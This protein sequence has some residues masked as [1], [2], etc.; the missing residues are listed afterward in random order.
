MGKPTSFPVAPLNR[1]SLV[2][3]ALSLGA[4][5][6][7]AAG[8]AAA[9]SPAGGARAAPLPPALTVTGNRPEWQDPM[10]RLL[11][12]FRAATDIEAVYQ[13][14][15][16]VDYLTILQTALA[17]GVVGDV[18]GFPEG[19][20]LRQAVGQVF[21]LRGR[22]AAD[23]LLP[24]ARAQVEFDNGVWGWPLSSYAIAVLYHPSLLAER[25]LAPP[26][27]WQELR[28]IWETLAADD[29]LA[30]NGVTPLVMPTGD[31]TAPYYW[32]CLAA[33]SVLGGEGWAAFLAGERRLTDPDLLEAGRLLTELAP[34]NAQDAGQL[35]YPAGLLRFG[36]GGAAMM[37]G[38]SA[39]AAALR[40]TE[41]DVDLGVVGFP[42]FETGFP[43]TLTGLE[44]ICTVSA[45]TSLIDQA[46]ALVGWLTTP[47][48]QQLVANYGLG[49]PVLPNHPPLDDPTLQAFVAARQ[50]DLPVWYAVPELQ[51]T[52]PT[53]TGAI[54]GL[55]AGKTSVD[56]FAAAM[57]AGVDQCLPTCPTPQQA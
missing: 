38:T 27:T 55:I 33:T 43:T 5:S 24:S 34:Y 53:A 31:S 54:G 6:T 44:L 7:L 8:L 17:G 3:R 41:R 12:D 48:T 28:A 42:A 37:V 45:F 13:A 22:V 21:D 1:R 56:D 26:T 35:D 52:F 4:G 51:E 23:A 2:R 11:A 9:R 14:F 50:A 57:Q 39:D 49:L 40:A 46:M 32:Y 18:I 29:R 47:E 20:Q 19:P 30:A 15:S 25:N 10:D 16:R 36:E